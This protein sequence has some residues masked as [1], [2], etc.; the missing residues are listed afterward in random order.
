M[1][2]NGNFQ[3]EYD[4][5]VCG[6]GPGGSTAAY[7]L[8]KKG[9][10]VLMLDKAKFPRVKVCAGWITPAI[11]ELLNLKPSDYPHT[12]QRFSS[13]SVIIDEK[14]YHT[15]FPKTASFGIIRK[16]FDNFLV[17]RAVDKGVIF[18]ESTTVSGFDILEDGKVKVTSSDG[19]TWNTKILIGAAG[20]GCPISK[21]WGYRSDEEVIV[22]ATE[23]ETDI[24]ADELKKLTPFYGTTELFA[25]P[26]FV[27]YGWYVTKGNFVNIGIGRFA[28]Q[29][30]N[31]NTDRDR[32]MALL[33]KMGRLN[34]IEERMVPFGRHAYKIHDE[35]GRKIFGDKFMLIGDSAGFASQWAGEGIKPAVQTAIFAAQVADEAIQAGDTSAKFLGKYK[36]LCDAE[37]GIQEKTIISRFLTLV[38][39]S[40]KKFV[41]TRICINDNLRKKIVFEKCFG[42]E[43][44][45]L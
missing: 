32:F 19:R 13:G 33:R 39:Q 30:E 8:V 10:K 15:H 4:V 29:T 2:G 44:T 5:I 36:D 7:E 1:N 6:A 18:Q 31:L 25:E 28:N 17:K 41:A 37:Y 21:K 9:R 27:G 40:V 3:G 14:Y 12:L 20:N 34:G 38:P 23:S 42:F 22:L 26:D 45:E 24:G 16:E 35:I 11:F 43:L